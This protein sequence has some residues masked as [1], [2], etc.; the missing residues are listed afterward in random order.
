MLH[1]SIIKIISLNFVEIVNVMRIQILNQS[2]NDLRKYIKV[3]SHLSLE[4][5]FNILLEWII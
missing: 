4:K 2:F 1:Q 3:K 5:H